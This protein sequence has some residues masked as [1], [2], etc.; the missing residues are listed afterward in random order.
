MPQIVATLAESVNEHHGVSRLSNQIY[1]GD[2]QD[3]ELRIG[4]TI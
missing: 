1:L 3:I 4:D 2:R